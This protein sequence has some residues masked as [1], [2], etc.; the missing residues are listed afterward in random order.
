MYY[1]YYFPVGLCKI[2]FDVTVKTARKKKKSI[3][4]AIRNVQ[5]D[6]CE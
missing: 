4:T 5:N 2:S 3:S 1:T 6:A